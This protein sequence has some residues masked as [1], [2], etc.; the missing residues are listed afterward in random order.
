MNDEIIDWILGKHERMVMVIP[1]ASKD[2]WT[3]HGPEALCAG[4]TQ[5][6]VGEYLSDIP[7]VIE[8]LGQDENEVSGI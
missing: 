6:F 8:A 1:A 5:I 7:D 2:P 3:L 4:C